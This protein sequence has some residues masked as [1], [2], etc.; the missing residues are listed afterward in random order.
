MKNITCSWKCWRVKSRHKSELLIRHFWFP[1]SL[2]RLQF[3]DAQ[4]LVIEP[5]PVAKMGIDLR[6]VRNQ[7]KSRT[8]FKNTFIRKEIN[9]FHLLLGE[10]IQKVKLTYWLWYKIHLKIQPCS[11][12]LDFYWKKKNINTKFCPL[13]P[14]DKSHGKNFS[15]FK[16]YTSSSILLIKDSKI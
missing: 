8:F 12:F 11:K 10:N 14:C 1:L 3:L 13:V 9:K 16:K 4:H 6:H 7:K 15:D 2:V 5:L